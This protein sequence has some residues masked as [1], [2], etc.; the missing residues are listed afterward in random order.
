MPV[1]VSD[2][3]VAAQ[4]EAGASR[5]GMAGS[6]WTDYT[7]RRW[8]LHD[9]A[10]GVVLSEGVDGLDFPD[11]DL[12]TDTT[13]L[14]GGRHRGSR[15][16]SRQITWPLY[17]SS[18]QN[19]DLDYLTVD[20]EFFNGMDP[21]RPGLW[22]WQARTGESRYL[23]CQYVKTGASVKSDPAKVG[24]GVYSID[25]V[26]HQPFWEGPDLV[27]RFQHAQPQSWLPSKD[28]PYVWISSGM[29]T[30]T[31]A[32]T[33]PGTEPAWPVWRV[34]GP[35]ANIVVGVGSQLTAIPFALGAGQTIT[36][37][38][39]QWGPNGFS[40]VDWTGRDRVQELTRFQPAPIPDGARVPVTASFDGAG[41]VVCTITPLYKRAW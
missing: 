19:T 18:K 27:A 28:R 15:A 40:A 22:E 25:L 4:V 29:D 1:L 16:Q 31:A 13:M 21:D 2:A 20:S 12:Y 35:A 24:W 39:R 34:E 32:V 17:I 23:W 6:W 3:F 41:A 37:D 26:A 30:Q 7:G 36:I 8:A 33:N 10:G 9:L 5:T 11:Y 14:P 38:T